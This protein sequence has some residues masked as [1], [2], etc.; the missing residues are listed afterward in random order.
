MMLLLQGTGLSRRKQAQQ[1]KLQHV[2]ALT[3]VCSLLVAPSTSQCTDCIHNS[4]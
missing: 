4:R 1:H 2:R 3:R